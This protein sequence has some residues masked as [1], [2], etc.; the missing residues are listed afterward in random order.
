MWIRAYARRRLGRV[1]R[2][3][4]HRRGSGPVSSPLRAVPPARRLRDL[5]VPDSD[6]LLATAD[7]AVDA[8]AGVLP[9][10]VALAGPAGLP[11]P[12]I[13]AAGLLARHGAQRGV[14][15]AALAAGAEDL[16]GAATRIRLRHRALA[17]EAGALWEHWSGPSADEVADRV[18]SLG[19]AAQEIVT[20]LEE[21]ADTVEGAGLAVADDVAERAA[22]ATELAAGLS[23]PPADPDTATTRA[24]AADLDARLHRYLDVA[25]RTDEAIA[26]TWRDLAERI[27]VLRRL[28]GRPVEPD[29]LAADAGA[30]PP[31]LLALPEILAALG[32]LTDPDLDLAD[33]A[34]LDDA[35]LDDGTSDDDPPGPSGPPGPAQTVDDSR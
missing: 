11:A 6:A 5:G 26:A 10:R 31:D 3:P 15:F 7:G 9:A 17:E 1:T 33:D 18:V 25:D 20:L 13:D 27:G 14:R 28:S 35:D 21:T 29:D 30:L 22:A 24:W 19:R 16:R 34:G 12:P 4:G 32:S 23:G 2:R 8:V